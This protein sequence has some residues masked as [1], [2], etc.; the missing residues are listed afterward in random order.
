MAII[1][2][3]LEEIDGKPIFVEKGQWL[4]GVF[5]G[6][7]ENHPI[8]NEE[9]VIKEFNRGYYRTSEEE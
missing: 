4:D 6:E 2:Y 8:A 3:H 1:I 9:E 7:L 5:S